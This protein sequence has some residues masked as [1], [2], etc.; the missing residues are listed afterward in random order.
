MMEIEFRYLHRLRVD[1][2]LK[3]QAYFMFLKRKLAV[4]PFTNMN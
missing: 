3:C 1:K 4:V 2:M